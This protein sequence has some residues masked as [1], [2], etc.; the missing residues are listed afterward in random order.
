ME[1][2]EPVIK[3]NKAIFDLSGCPCFGTSCD[4]INNSNYFVPFAPNNLGMKVLNSTLII[5]AG[6]CRK[7]T[8]Y[9]YI[10]SVEEGGAGK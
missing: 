8:F 3:K 4:E 9:I 6:Y 2:L 1:I 5:D 7:E 10:N